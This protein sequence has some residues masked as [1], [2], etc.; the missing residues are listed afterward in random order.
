MS[1]S[2]R[3]QG[4]SAT[5]DLPN[6]NM[7]RSVAVLL[8]LFGHL[9]AFMRVRGL[10]D[11]GHFG[12][13]LF[14]VHTALVLMLSMERLGLSGGRLYSVFV[15]RRVFRIYPLSI[16]AVLFVVAFQVP[17]APWLSGFVWPGWLG[18]LSNVLL[19]QNITRSGSVLCVLWSLP[20]EVQ[21]YAFLPLFYILIRRFPSLRAMSLIWLTGVVAAGLEYFVRIGNVDSGFLF[22]RY[23]PSFLAG[24]FAWQLM[25]TRRRRFSGA[26]W[27]FV[28]LALVI[29]YRLEDVFQVYGS[30]WLD[31]LSGGFRAD[32]HFSR[33][34]YVELVRDWLFCGITGLAIPF[35]SD[36]TSSWLNAITRKIAQ[37]S[38]GVY[39]CHV[40]LLWLC[41]DLL[42]IGNTAVCAVLA[43]FLTALVSYA[44][45]HFIEH[46][47]IQSGKRISIRLANGIAFA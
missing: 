18:I 43:V 47:A 33:P 29:V 26:L 1:N 38:Y 6:L 40:P 4:R 32:Q 11:V 20:F 34:P 24:V 28:L 22:L 42:H 5:G 10:G 23:F 9:T 21:M 41:F 15:I 46:P 16:L 35:F 12:V 13:L 3:G 14:F 8:V 19:I 27:V 17:S 30:N 37:Y 36:V 31:A 39:L 25:A 44:L 45:Y 2:I 7:L